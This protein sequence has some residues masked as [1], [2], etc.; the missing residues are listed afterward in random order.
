MNM[1]AKLGIAAI[2]LLTAAGS[3]I[4]SEQGIQARINGYEVSCAM[5]GDDGIA[6][7]GTYQ[8][9]NGIDAARLSGVQKKTGAPVLGELDGFKKG[10]QYITVRI[11]GAHGTVSVSRPLSSS[12]MEEARGPVIPEFVNGFAEKCRRLLTP[13]S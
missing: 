12:D 13:V 8:N 3:A 9:P 6:F 10:Q 2:S 7:K 1:P 4:A 11:D 5:T